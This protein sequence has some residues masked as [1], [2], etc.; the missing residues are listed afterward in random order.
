MFKQR[1]KEKTRELIFN[2]DPHHVTLEVKSGS[3]LDHQVKMIGLTVEDLQILHTLQPY[4]ME[5]IGLIIDRFYSNLE[6]EASLIHIINEYSSIE[7]LKQTLRRHIVEMFTG[8]ID[9]E[10]IK[11]RY[12]VA[13][14]HVKIGLEAKW[15]LA[16]FQDILNS[17][18]NIIEEHVPDREESFL[19]FRAASKIINLEEQLVLE[20]YEEEIDRIKQT[21]AAEKQ[22]IQVEI[23]GTSESL[24]AVSLQTNATMEELI[25]QSDGMVALAKRGSSLSESAKSKAESGKQELNRFTEKM[26]S[27]T[28]SVEG[29]RTDAEELEKI[30]QQMQEIINLVSG[31]A[32]QTNLL[33]LNASI[34]AARAGESGRGFAVVAEEVRK[35]SDQT[36]DAVVNVASLIK[37]TTE[38]VNY[39]TLTLDTIRRDV[40]IGNSY[41]KDTEIHFEEIVRTMNDTDTQN[42]KMA[43]EIQLF[44]ESMSVLGESFEEVAASADSL[45]SLTTK[46]DG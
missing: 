16:A 5:N 8:E 20:A 30:M 24:A 29:I 18:I 44:C 3:A 15:Y 19:A 11:K 39:L 40:Q 10:Y 46:L 32:E 6:K 1:K 23:T 7:R 17:L 45:N 42:N 34:E 33:S 36:K 31:V 38:Q 13:H 28:A 9:A 14:V 35:L 4:V 25:A 26:N 2:K 22:N 27:I 21:I 41:S 43:D 37:N 12:I